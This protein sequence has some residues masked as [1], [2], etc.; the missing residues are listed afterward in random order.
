MVRFKYEDIEE[1]RRFDV[2]N[3]DGYDMILGTPFLYEWRRDWIHYIDDD[4]YCQRRS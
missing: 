4:R 3:I 1:D 2:M